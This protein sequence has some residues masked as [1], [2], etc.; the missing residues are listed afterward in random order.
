[1]GRSQSY[2]QYIKKRFWRIYPELWI[3]VIFELIVLV[4]LYDQWELKSLLLFAF[5]QGTIFQFWTPDSLRGYGVGTPNGALWTIG[6]MIQFY[7]V[8][9]LFFKLMRN[10]S[11]K[12]WLVGFVVSFCISWGFGYITESIVGNEIVGKLY[13][14]TFV[15]YFWLFYIGMFIAEFK[16]RVLP[17]LQQ[18]WYG[19]LILGFIFFWTKIDLL[20]GYY[21]GWSICLAAGLIG[22]AYRFPGLSVSPDISYGLFLYH[23]TVVNAF[24]QLG[25]IGKWSYAVPVVALVIL[26]AYISTLTIGKFS[27]T[28]KQS[29]VEGRI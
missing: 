5:G 6:V 21:L 14:Q 13:G 25:L 26:F 27:A 28:R 22:F 12:E 17:V 19:F 23:M 20:A 7:I 10:R 24:V 8:I 11:I 9:W 1:M 16:N 29:I 15:K 4:V 2:G 18:Y 3:A